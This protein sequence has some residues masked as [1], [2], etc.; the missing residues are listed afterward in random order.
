M[1]RRVLFGLSLFALM[2]SACG[3]ASSSAES[4]PSSSD[5]SSSLSEG[6][7]TLTPT[8][9]KLRFQ[10]LPDGKS[11]EVMALSKDIEGAVVIPAT[12]Q[13]LPVTRFHDCAF[14]ECDKITSIDIPS[15]I[16]YIDFD[17]FLFTRLLERVTIDP[18]NAVYSSYDGAI[19]DKEQAEFLFC[20][21][22]KK[23]TY[24]IPDSVLLVRA[25]AFS[26]CAKLTAINIPASVTKIGDN[27]F[28]E[29]LSLLSLNVDKANRAFS[30][31]EGVLLNKT[32]TTIILCPPGKKG[33]YLAPSSVDTIEKSAFHECRFLTS[34]E[35]PRG[36][37][38]I[39]AF[40]FMGCSALFSI[41][42]PD[43]VV[44]I[45]ECAFKECTEL[46]S[47][48]IPASVDALDLS[49]FEC[50]YALEA[51]NV[52]AGNQYY[53]SNQ[54][55]LLNEEGTQLLLCPAGKQGAFIVPS[56]VTSILDWSFDYCA[57]LTSVHIPE[58]VAEIGDAFRFC[59]AI[60]AFYVAEENAHYSSKEGVLFNKDATILLHCPSGK[61]GDYDIP[62]GVI[63]LQPSCFD[64][65]ALLESVTLPE[66]IATL[67]KYAFYLC[68]KI[69]R[70]TLPSTLKPIGDS[71]FY[72]CSSLPSIVLPASV[73]EIGSMAFGGC[74]AL[75]SITFLGTKAQWNAVN[76]L[77]EDWAS[78][79]L[80]TSVSC[81]DGAVPIVTQGEEE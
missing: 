23:G 77:D 7:S 79:I 63:T 2:L 80:A 48:R 49:A 66:G 1:N 36:L 69:S 68:E 55:A 18:E 24:S 16:A 39:R 12:Y 75:A 74:Q 42:I 5:V 54:G 21:A 35:L 17:G 20:P 78:G 19:L 71:A 11:Y 50:C 72:G 51:I 73:N 34:I 46:Q 8:L 57:K 58:S 25:L 22:G 47:I 61:S 32:Q 59:P 62:S 64:E 43:T 33:S 29:C 38:T 9:E 81:S 52:D 45:E 13:G 41:N 53:S 28:S 30:S 10:L 37:L 56:G 3:N 60:S 14:T 31:V 40:A 27:A 6:S 65:C 67:P 76:F 44:A 26:D 4:L 70:V 15:T